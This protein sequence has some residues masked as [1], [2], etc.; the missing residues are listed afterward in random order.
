MTGKK[1]IL[2]MKKPRYSYLGF[3]LISFTPVTDFIPTPPADRQKDDING[4]SREG[5]C[6]MYYT[7]MSVCVY[8]FQ[9][10]VSL[11]VIQMTKKASELV[12]CSQTSLT[13]K[14]GLYNWAGM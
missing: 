12:K 3:I 6:N 13:N 1:K 5:R 7:S 4:R 8:V 2:W 10:L 11:G 9:R 14:T